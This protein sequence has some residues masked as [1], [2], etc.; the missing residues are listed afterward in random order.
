VPIGVETPR[1]LTPRSKRSRS[2]GKSQQAKLANAPVLSQSVLGGV[3]REEVGVALQL[4][5]RLVHF[6]VKRWIHRILLVRSVVIDPGNPIILAAS[7]VVVLMGLLP[8]I[9]LNGSF[10]R[11]GLAICSGRAI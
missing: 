1:R 7:F 2:A 6:Y 4:L 11:R 9:V 5:K 8:L 10:D 3:N